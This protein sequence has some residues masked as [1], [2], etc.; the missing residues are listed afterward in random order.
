M[1]KQKLKISMENNLKIKRTCLAEVDPKSHTI[2]NSTILYY[3]ILHYII[4]YYTILYYTT[5]GLEVPEVLPRAAPVAAEHTEGPRRYIL[6]HHRLLYRYVYSC[7][8][9]YIY[10]HT[11]KQFVLHTERLVQTL[12]RSGR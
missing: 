3:T 12:R 6:F 9:I 5:G 2:L 7:V 4:L 10:T 8:Y 1:F 11:Y